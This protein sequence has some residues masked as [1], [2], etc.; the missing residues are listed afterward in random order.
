MIAARVPMRRWLFGL[1]ASALVLMAGGCAPQVKILVQSPAEIS[2]KGIK[3]IAIGSFEVAMAEQNVQIERNGVWKTKKLAFTRE[4]KAQIAK[5]VRAKIVNVL[6]ASPYFSL[7]Y[8]DEFAGLENDA[9]LQTLISA[10]G[11]K[12]RQVDAVINGK[13]WIQSEK[14]D[15]SDIAK[16]DMKYVE[17]GSQES[18]DLSVQKMLWWPYKAMRGNLTLEMKLTRLNPTEIVAVN[19]E[20]RTFSHRIGGKL[21]GALD[22]LALAKANLSALSQD[23]QAKIE[24]SNAVFPSFGQLVSDLATS[25]A[26]NFVRRVA[27]TEKWVGYPVATE[28]DER[29]RLLIEAGAYEM[30]IERLQEVTRRKKDTSDLYNLGLAHEAIGEYGLAHTFYTDAWER[31][32]NCL[33]YAQGLGRLEKTL[34]EYPQVKRQLAEKNQ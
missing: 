6:G 25:S 34:R 20:T 13:L 11:Y 29:G 2:T 32:K 28:G 7:V 27:V 9:A 16:A 1:T 23:K 31:D 33:L 8:T 22:S 15:G 4:Q 18:L 3:K 30:A 26:T 10:E 5:Q 14:T 17:G 21:E 12:T 24:N 19:T